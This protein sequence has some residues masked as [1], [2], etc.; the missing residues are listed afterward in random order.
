LENGNKFKVPKIPRQE[1]TPKR[2][3]VKKV[4]VPRPRKVI[5][6]I[7]RRSSSRILERFPFPRELFNKTLDSATLTELQEKW[8]NSHSYLVNAFY[9]S[10][11]L[12]EIDRRKALA[13]ASGNIRQARIL[14]NGSEY[15]SLIQVL[16]LY[17][18]DCHICKVAI[19]LKASRRVG[20]GDWLL[21]LHIDHLIAIALGGADTLANVRPSH[22]ICNLKKG[23][24]VA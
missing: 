10:Q 17:G 19:D 14:E 6:A 20:V 12:D 9:Q 13:R 5:D 2:V 23:A 18:K 24:R 4:K 8:L 15:Y 7:A 1:L 21:G 3:K 16:L 11:R 22:A